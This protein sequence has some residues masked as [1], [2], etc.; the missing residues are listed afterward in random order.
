MAD[1]TD[2]NLQSFDNAVFLALNRTFVKEIIKATPTKTGET[3]SSWELVKISPFNYALN[4]EN[5]DIVEILEYGSKAHKITPKNKKALRWVENGKE[6]FA[7]KVNHPGTEARLFISKILKN[8]SIYN[9][10]EKELRTILKR[11]GL[12]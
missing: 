9:S 12:L 11:K 2:F 1:L 3:A 10:F 4:N 5:G 7:K 6:R 8:K